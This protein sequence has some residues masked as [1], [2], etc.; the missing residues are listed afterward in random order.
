MINPRKQPLIAH[1]NLRYGRSRHDGRVHDGNHI[2]LAIVLRIF[3]PSVPMDR[4]LVQPHKIEENSLSG[5][6]YSKDHDC[7]NQQAL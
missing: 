7:C 1:P 5:L 3:D 4:A 2:A 6:S